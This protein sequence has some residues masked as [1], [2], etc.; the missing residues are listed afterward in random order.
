MGS[1]RSRDSEVR[2][3][4]IIGL[5]PQLRGQLLKVIVLRPVCGCAVIKNVA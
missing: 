4:P 5:A 3:L 2:A 1:P